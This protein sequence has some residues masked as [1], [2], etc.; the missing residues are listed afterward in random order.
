MLAPFT[1]P[2]YEPLS[3]ATCSFSAVSV[4]ATESAAT[5][6]MFALSGEFSTAE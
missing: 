3:D 2:E 6:L 4:N 5:F 1:V